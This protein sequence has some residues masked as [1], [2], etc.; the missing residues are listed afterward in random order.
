MVHFDARQQVESIQK[1]LEQVH[2]IMAEAMIEV[3]A[4][5]KVIDRILETSDKWRLKSVNQQG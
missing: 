4:S 1:R 2:L 5:R 3:D